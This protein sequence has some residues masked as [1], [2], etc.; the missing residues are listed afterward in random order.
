MADVPS[1]LHGDSEFIPGDTVRPLTAVVNIVVPSA[2]EDVIINRDKSGACKVSTRDIRGEYI[3]QG[4]NGPVTANAEDRLSEMGIVSFPD[5]LAN[6]G[7]VL[8]SYMEWLNGLIRV[9]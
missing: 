8:A 1:G 2:L 9:F 6:A 5:I 3:L 4:A 7:G